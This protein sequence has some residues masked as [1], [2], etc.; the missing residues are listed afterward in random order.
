MDEE[1]WRLTFEEEWMYSAVLERRTFIP[2]SPDWDHEHCVLCQDKF[3]PPPHKALQ[4]GFVH[5]AE[6]SAEVAMEEERTFPISD[7]GRIVAAPTEERWICDTCLHDFQPRFRW[8]VKDS[9]A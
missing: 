6:R 7:S 5:G 4:E 9:R 1:D 2:S 8:I 3:M